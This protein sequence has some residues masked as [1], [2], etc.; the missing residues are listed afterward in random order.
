MAAP[1][2]PLPRLK[3]LAREQGTS[4]RTMAKVIGR[5]EGY[6]RRRLDADTYILDLRGE[7]LILLAAFFG[8]PV[9][10]LGG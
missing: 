8:V 6:V 4:V 2:H 9:R 5:S 7:E 10:E 3:Q 1:I